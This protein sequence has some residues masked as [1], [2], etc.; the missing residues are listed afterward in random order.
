[1]VASYEGAKIAIN[2]FKK[3]KFCYFILDEAHKIKNDEG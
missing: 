3:I 1:M 2:T